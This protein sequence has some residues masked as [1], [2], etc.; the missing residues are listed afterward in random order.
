MVALFV[1][2]TIIT[3]LT[4]DYLVQRAEGR[5]AGAAGLAAGLAATPAV[6]APAAAV[7]LP[8]ERIPP[9]LFFD[10]GHTWAEIE[11]TGSVRI[12]ADPIAATLL[13]EPEAIELPAAGARV[14]RGEPI[15]RIR[16]GGRELVLRSPADGV[17]EAV[18]RELAI[19]P[20]RLPRDPFG[21]SWLVRFAPGGLAAVVKS[22]LAGDEALAWLRE[23]MVQLR[24]TIA[25]LG[26]GHALAGATLQDGGLPA[27]GLAAELDPDD[28][29]RI[30]VTF[31]GSWRQQQ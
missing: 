22:M 30:A 14:A 2:L 31:F 7:A 12:G 17:I 6:P 29:A 24:D 27:A 4:I 11:P 19:D 9:G 1:V 28:W 26:G 23:E 8:L 3:F 18:N 16:R 21:A 25:L 15:A 20:A 10:R 13:G 5:R